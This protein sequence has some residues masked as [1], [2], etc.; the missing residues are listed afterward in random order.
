[1][2]ILVVGSGGR[3]HAIAWRLAQDAAKHDIYCAPGN[4]GIAI[5]LDDTVTEKEEDVLVP[6][7]DEVPVD[8]PDDP[9]GPVGIVGNDCLHPGP[10][11]VSDIRF[12]VDGPYM[13]IH[14][15]F[16]ACLQES[17]ILQVI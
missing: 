5:I 16:P 8:R 1:M 9:D 2:K 13:D 10:D 17:G 12:L 3:E 6:G 14:A 7:W 4:A 15:A 11:A